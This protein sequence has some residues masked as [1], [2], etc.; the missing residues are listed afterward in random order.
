MMISPPSNCLPVGRDSTKGRYENVVFN[1]LLAHFQQHG[2]GWTAAEAKQHDGGGG[3][4]YVF[5]HKLT[6]LMTYTR[7][8]QKSLDASGTKVPAWLQ[9]W[10]EK[11]PGRANNLDL[12]MLR[13]KVDSI[14][15]LMTRGWARRN[16]WNEVLVDVEEFLRQ[17]ERLCTRRDN[18]RAKKQE[19]ASS[20]RSPTV[21]MQ[22]RTVEAR[23]SG[24]KTTRYSELAQMM[25]SAADFQEVFVPV[26]M[27]D[28]AAPVQAVT[29]RDARKSFRRRYWAELGLPCRVYYVCYSPGECCPRVL[30]LLLRWYSY[31]LECACL[32]VWRDQTPTTTTTARCWLHAQLAR[33]SAWLCM[34]HAR[35]APTKPQSAFLSSFR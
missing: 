12:A 9:P 4:G 1:K 16:G 3:D 10:A 26:S 31:V 13:A 32:C 17:L 8:T 33:V 35:Q 34:L 21:G 30:L 5:L 18:E 2:V 23:F 15:I 14:R 25:Q 19:S 6:E 24:S 11:G 28:D 7:G 20:G 29:T 22:T 27:V